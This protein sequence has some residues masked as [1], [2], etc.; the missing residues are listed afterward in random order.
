MVT[1]LSWTIHIS[2][3]VSDVGCGT[4]DDLN[5]MV[6]CL[7]DTPKRQLLTTDFIPRGV[8][9]GDI[10]GTLQPVLPDVPETLLEEGNVNQVKIFF[11]LFELLYLK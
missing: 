10:S 11:S 5:S 3:L 9:D 7:Q 1:F 2:R 6:S 4:S 8:V